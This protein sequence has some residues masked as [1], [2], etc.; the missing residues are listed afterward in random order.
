[1][2]ELVKQRKSAVNY[3]DKVSIDKAMYMIDHEENHTKAMRQDLIKATRNHDHDK[4]KETHD[5]VATHGKYTN[6]GK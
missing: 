1:M 4:I 5:Y 3:K 6:D 2:E